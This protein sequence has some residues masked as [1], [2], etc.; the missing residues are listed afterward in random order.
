MRRT[1]QERI[2]TILRVDECAEGDGEVDNG[3]GYRDENSGGDEENECCAEVESSDQNGADT[4]VSEAGV[5]FGN[6]T[7]LSSAHIHLFAE[8]TS[9]G[10]ELHLGEE[11]GCGKQH[12]NY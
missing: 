8:F 4:D 1:R 10:I 3:D 12:L 11:I 7:G 9:I 5:Y 2:V 6:E